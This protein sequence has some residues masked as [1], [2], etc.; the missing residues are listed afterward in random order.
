VRRPGRGSKGTIVSNGDNPGDGAGAAESWRAEM[1]RLYAGTLAAKMETLE[2]LVAAASDTPRDAAARERLHDAVHKIR[3]SAGAYGFGALSEVAA[4]WE[5]ALEQDGGV[6]RSR[7]LMGRLGEVA[8]AAL[9]E[10]EE[11]RARR[12]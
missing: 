12:G 3:G 11:G 8:R 2:A 10:E 6:A 7:E 5:T 4:E 9:A 1:R